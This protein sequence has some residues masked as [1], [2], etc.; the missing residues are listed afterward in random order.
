MISDTILLILSHTVKG[1][2]RFGPWT[3]VDESPGAFLRTVVNLFLR[4]ATATQLSLICRYMTSHHLNLLFSMY[5]CA[6]RKKVA[7]FPPSFL[8]SLLPSL[9]VVFSLL[10]DWWLVCLGA[11]RLTHKATFN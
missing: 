1:T 6:K 10:A 11:S 2:S 7:P 8:P 5:V 3:L 4:R 9:P